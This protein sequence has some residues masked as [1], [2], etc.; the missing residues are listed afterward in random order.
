MR[1][2]G[3]PSRRP[4]A[5]AKDEAGGEASEVLR[6]LR[7]V[8]RLQEVQHQAQEAEAAS[9]TFFSTLSHGTTLSSCQVLSDRCFDEMFTG[10]SERHV[11]DN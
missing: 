3:D 7:E 2:G 8:R 9:G 4:D 1:G 5:E 11:Y 10:L 6:D